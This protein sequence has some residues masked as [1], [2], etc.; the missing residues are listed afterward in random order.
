MAQQRRHRNHRTDARSSRPAQRR[1]TIDQLDRMCR[2]IDGADYG[3]YKKL[4]GEYEAG[5]FRL[6]VDK[7]QSDPF[8]SPSKIRVI[9]PRD[10]LDVGGE[11]TATRGDRI[12]VADVLAR[13]AAA[14]LRSGGAP[15]RGGGSGKS[16][17]ISI[18]ALGQEVLERTNVLVGERDVEFRLLVGLPARGRRVLGKQAA[19]LLTQDVPRLA[20]RAAAVSRQALEDAVWLLRDQEALRAELPGRGLV[21]FVA[22]GANLPRAS[23]ASD[24]PLS[25]GVPFRSPEPLRVTF[26]L[27]SG[28][29]VTGMGVPEGLTV[30]VGGGYHGK[31]TLLRA[32]ERG[33]YPHTLGDGR[34]F[35]ITRADA[36]TVRAED[37]RPVTSQDISAFIANLPNG[38]D[39]AHFSTANASG[40]TSQAANV[41]EALQASASTLLIDEDTS[42]TNFMI[43]DTV[44]AEL[45]AADREP[46]TPFSARV[47][48]LYE[49]L[50]VS[51][52]L[53]A[54]GSGAYL[55]LA[56]TVIALDAYVPSDVTERA[57]AVGR[58]HEPAQLPVTPEMF[59][60]DAR[61]LSGPTFVSG[62]SGGGR[63]RGPKARG[64]DTI[65][66]GKSDIDMSFL[67]QLAGAPQTA[68]IAAA[69]E[70]LDEWCGR[71]GAPVAVG[72]E[73]LLG[74]LEAD[75]LAALVPG[76]AHPGHL[77]A[78]RRFEILAAVNRYRGLRTG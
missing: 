48:G 22:D 37:G 44:M 64:Q 76:R 10:A 29:T 13:E 42:A 78:P 41:I 51:T 14:L 11:F 46:I 38:A 52:V 23:G 65:S 7:V 3:A 61:T 15:G 19:Q 66:V 4:A 5:E 33:V 75:G 28:R 60:P 32:L 9:V 8:A 35:A 36:V 24:L 77:T 45:I 34:E 72:V 54:G 20:Q 6:V 56:D 73:K 57:H 70:R 55:G 39:T 25:G 59:A 53:V 21:A 67:P 27:P 49:E 62:G 43:R 17:T 58:G 63:R 2:D 30:I 26:D 71:G 12:A 1:G 31:S 68:A 74:E 18:G 47:R 69:L 40:S 50:G 16:N